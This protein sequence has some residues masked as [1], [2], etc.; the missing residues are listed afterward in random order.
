MKNFQNTDFKKSEPKTN[1]S[2]S[3]TGVK[4]TL[5]ALFLTAF[6]ISCD[7][8]DIQQDV[9]TDGTSKEISNSE[10]SR[11]NYDYGTIIVRAWGSHNVDCSQPNGFCHN[12]VWISFSFFR[13][14][15][16]GTPVRVE[17]VDGAYVMKIYKSALTEEHKRTLLR[18]GT[19]YSI[20]EGQTIPQEFVES[21]G[22]SSNTLR[23]GE[24]R[25]A[26]DRDSYTIS[27]P[28]N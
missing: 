14:Q 3:F 24:Y 21:L 23:Q 8:D 17:N 26:E 4:M 15:P 12:I 22:F 11:Y 27:V 13:P 20:P 6:M 19:Y 16:T 18:N 7:K 5:V 10:A 1:Q 2:V 25:I 9:K 28:V